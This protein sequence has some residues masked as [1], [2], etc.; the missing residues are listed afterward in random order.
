MA[1]FSQIVKECLSEGIVPATQTNPLTP[2][3][4]KQGIKL[5]NGQKIG[6]DGKP[7]VQGIGTAQQIGIQKPAASLP[8]PG[9][10]N[11]TSASTA[12][13][14]GALNSPAPTNTVKADPINGTVQQNTAANSQKNGLQSAT[15]TPNSPT[16]QPTKQ[17][18]NKSGSG[19]AANPNAPTDA[20]PNAN[21][22]VSKP[23]L[24][25]KET[26]KPKRTRKTKVEKTGE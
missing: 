21:T 6:P 19:T 17:M 9:A 25:S 23:V 14:P 1:T 18:V 11:L 12:A 24:A 10:K 26:E 20:Q 15:G 16:P 22:N 3:E 4:M 7:V 2:E 8:P 5:V 13:P